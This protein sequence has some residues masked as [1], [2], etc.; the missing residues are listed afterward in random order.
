MPVDKRRV[1]VVTGAGRATGIGQA[2]AQRLLREGFAVAISDI[3]QA[4]SLPLS[5]IATTVS[6]LERTAKR[7][8]ND[9]A[10][11]AYDCDVRSEQQVDNLMAQ[12]LERFGRLDVLVNNAGLSSGL[13][14]VTDVTL[15]EWQLNIDVMATGVFLY[16]RAAARIMVDTKSRGRIIT[17]AS[18]AGK[19]GIGQLAAYSAAKFAAIGFTQALAQE[20]GSSGIT[21][22]SVCP[23][24]I[25]T[26]LNEVD[27]GIFDVYAKLAGISREEYK[28]RF[29]RHIPVQ[30][31]GTVD[32]IAAIV[33][34]LA[35]EEASFVTGAAFNVTG[36]QEMH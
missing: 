25:D 28:R 33:A 19:T 20:L 7:L 30:R 35:S 36:G 6:E 27:G 4:D 15:T 1:A 3:G 14:P 10:V 8:E 9:G 23:G 5:G 22:N 32:D 12:V 29:V 34:F 31:F 2:I 21:V 18:Q 17:I 24:T 16:S 11:V 13:K 26:P